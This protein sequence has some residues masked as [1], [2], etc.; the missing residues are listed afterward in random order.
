MVGFLRHSR[1]KKNTEREGGRSVVSFPVKN[2]FTLLG[3]IAG[4]CSLL[5][6]G[7]AEIRIY[8]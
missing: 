1:N 2:Q 8:F 7:T 3:Y 6:Y 4:I 5:F